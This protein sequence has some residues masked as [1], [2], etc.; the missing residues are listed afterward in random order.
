MGPQQVPRSRVVTAY[1]IVA[2]IELAVTAQD[3]VGNGVQKAGGG[4]EGTIVPS[5]ISR[6]CLGC[7]DLARMDDHHGSCLGNSLT[8][9]DTMSLCTTAEGGYDELVV[10]MCRVAVIEARG[11]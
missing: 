4:I 9:K 10:K 7:V 2:E 5:I 6:C 11:A 8:A 1:D 3:I